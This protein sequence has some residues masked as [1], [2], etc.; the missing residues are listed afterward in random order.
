MAPDGDVVVAGGF[1][2][3]AEIDGTPLVDAGS[4]DGFVAR[5]APDGALRWVKSIGGPSMDFARCVAVTPDGNLVVAGYF[6]GSVDFGGGPLE[7]NG[8]MQDVFVV[9]LDAQGEHRWSK[10]YGGTLL[11]APNAVAV[12][13]QGHSYVTGHFADTAEIGRASCRERV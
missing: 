6:G 10:A 7:S 9:G 1:N 3:A 5:Y 11:D 8:P 12:D 13:T 2:G 4:G